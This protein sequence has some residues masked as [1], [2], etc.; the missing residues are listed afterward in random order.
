VAPPRFVEVVP[1]KSAQDMFEAVT[2][3]A[4]EFDIIIKAAAVSDYTPTTVA[5]SKMKKTDDDLSIPLKRTQDILK[6]LGAHKKE[7]QFLCGFSMETDNMIENSR[8]KLSSKNC[9]MI[10]ANSLRTAGAGFGVDTNI[11]TLITTDGET[12]LPQMSKAAA[13][14]RIFD[15]ILARM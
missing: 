9:D 5:D 2:S 3:R 13:A 6:H 1:V 7:G 11:I 14:H 4:P 15:T 12:E 10:C 8:K